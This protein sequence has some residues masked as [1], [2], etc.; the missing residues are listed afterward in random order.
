MP[1]LDGI[2]LMRALK[3]RPETNA[4][5]IAIVTSSEQPSDRERA[6]DAG[7]CAFLRKPTGMNAMIVMIQALAEQCLPS[8]TP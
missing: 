5:P 8:A 3:S 1:R 6:I 7:C 4:I 2:E